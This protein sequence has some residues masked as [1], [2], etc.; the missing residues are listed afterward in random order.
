MT[1]AMSWSCEIKTSACRSLATISSGLY[2][3]FGIAVLLRI[4]R[5]TSGRTA[6]LAEAQTH[7][8][9]PRPIRNVNV[10]FALKH[11]EAAITLFQVA[12]SKA[13]RTKMVR[14]RWGFSKDKSH[15]ETPFPLYRI[16]AAGRAGV[17]FR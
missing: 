3:L 15:G 17:H 10:S 14:P 1:S 4:K 12:R 11:L 7:Q 2:F 9:A 16:Q 8:F 6:F 13:F 5:Q